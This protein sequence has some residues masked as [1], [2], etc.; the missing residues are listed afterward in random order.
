MPRLARVDVGGEVYHVLNR[1]VGRL[2]I[3]NTDTDYQ[4]FEDILL[5]AKDLTGMRILAYT[6]MPN[7]WHLVLHPNDD[8][9]LGVFMHRLTNAHTRRVHVHTKTNG[10][11]PLYQGRY[12]SFLV[13]TDQYYLTLL[14]YVERNPVRAKLVKVCEDWR[15]GSAYRR[16]AG[17]NVEHMILDQSPVQLPSDYTHWINTP[18]TDSELVSIRNSVNKGAPYGRLDWV[19]MMTERFELETTRRTVGRPK[20]HD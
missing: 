14:K 7:H 17:E 9:D 10:Q 4:L 2:Q 13:D 16:H 19:D 3:F 12:K 5:E 18:D 11:G 15:W 1:A 6:I 20:K 8:G